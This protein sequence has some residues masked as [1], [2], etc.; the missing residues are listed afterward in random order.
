MK[1]DEIRIPARSISMLVT[2][3]QRIMEDNDLS[4]KVSDCGKY[5]AAH[6]IDELI[7]NV[8]ELERRYHEN[9]FYYSAVKDENKE[10]SDLFDGYTPDL[11]DEEEKAEVQALVKK[12]RE[13][14]ESKE[15]G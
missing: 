10:Y 2:M 15:D 6:Y 3:K 12:W 5:A 14:D 7:H 13:K 11:L 1:K 8:L 9:L 4:C